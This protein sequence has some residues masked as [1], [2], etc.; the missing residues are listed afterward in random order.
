MATEHDMS[1]EEL[2]HGYQHSKQLAESIK[3][4]QK[5][6]YYL[7]TGSFVLIIILNYLFPNVYWLE[8]RPVYD[9]KFGLTGLFLTFFGVIIFINVL[10]IFKG[11]LLGWVVLI[12]L[13]IT[14]LYFGL[15]LL[16][17]LS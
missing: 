4:D 6:L 2:L 16:I 5:W 10:F 14:L 13:S 15:P 12:A 8:K 11:S 1:K 3:N 9:F 7:I 17:G